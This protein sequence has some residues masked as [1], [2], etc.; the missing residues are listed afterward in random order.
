MT[1]F[2]ASARAAQSDQASAATSGSKNVRRAIH[3]TDLRTALRGRAPNPRSFLS[4][5]EGDTRARWAAPRRTAHL[6]R[7]DHL[8]SQRLRGV[9]APRRLGQVL[10]VPGDRLRP[11]VPCSRSSSARPSRKSASSERGACG[12]A[13]T[14]RQQRRAR[15]I[16]PPSISGGVG[17]GEQ[18]LAGRRSR[19]SR[20]RRRDRRPRGCGPSARSPDRRPSGACA[21]PSRGDVRAR[22]SDGAACNRVR[23]RR[24]RERRGWRRAGRR[25]A[26][27][28]IV[29]VVGLFRRDH[30]LRPRQA[31]DQALASLQRDASV[32]DRAAD[33]DVTVSQAAARTAR[34]TG[35]TRR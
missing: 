7:E 25:R 12:K 28:N 20:R 15:Q 17:E 1:T 23:D 33:D 22:C 30:G 8:S 5:S 26:G 24:A 13:T 9:G 31:D 18:V 10:V 19:G 27:E 3:G 2:A 34:S 16:R 35:P 32:D 4:E 6:V 29:R 21:S 14:L 11:A